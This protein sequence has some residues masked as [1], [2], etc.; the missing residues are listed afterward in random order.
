MKQPKDCRHNLL[1][2]VCSNGKCKRMPDQSV[3]VELALHD[4]YEYEGAKTQKMKQ[5]APKKIEDHSFCL[6]R[7]VQIFKQNTKFSFCAI[8]KSQKTVGNTLMLNLM[9]Q[10]LNEVNVPVSMLTTVPEGSVVCGINFIREGLSGVR[11]T[12]VPLVLEPASLVYSESSVLKK[13]WFQYAGR[14]LS[15]QSE[16]QKKERQALAIASSKKQ[17]NNA[18]G[19]QSLSSRG[20]GS[21]S[22]GGSKRPRVDLDDKEEKE[23]KRAVNDILAAEVEEDENDK[24]INDQAGDHWEF[25]L[26][27]L[28]LT[29]GEKR[30]LPDKMVA[31]FHAGKGPQ[32]D[33]SHDGKNLAWNW[34]ERSLRTILSD[35]I[36]ENFIRVDEKADLQEKVM[37]VVHLLVK[38]REKAVAITAATVGGVGTA[39]EANN[40]RTVT[41]TQHE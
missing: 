8:V 17:S 10:S 6:L 13:W 9:D 7:D 20:N 25:K 4:F 22:Q 38:E 37:K 31:F 21:K 15:L 34:N 30:L 26:V 19:M 27:P 29:W 1:Y 39:I 3:E 23:V 5:V 16:L 40:D 18:G 32:I 11:S 28:Q 2:F 24:F 35:M 41:V 14:A 36:S 12:D 33:P